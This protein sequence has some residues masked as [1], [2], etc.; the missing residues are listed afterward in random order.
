MSEE[1]QVP[2]ER[3]RLNDR[4]IEGL[5]RQ[6]RRGFLGGLSRL[7]LLLV[8]TLLGL[9]LEWLQP[10]SAAVALAYA[11]PGAV[12]PD[13]GCPECTGIC[14][15]CFSAC[16]CPCDTGCVCTCLA[17]CAAC[18]PVAFRSHLLWILGYIP[19]CVCEAC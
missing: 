11:Q 18:I 14:D 16:C 9:E 2:R 4:L 6:S 7:G 5:M 1:R 13:L 15:P 12:T 10:A 3:R 17:G 8:G 19:N